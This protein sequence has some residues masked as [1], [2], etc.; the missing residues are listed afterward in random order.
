MGRR[1]EK[2]RLVFVLLPFD[3]PH[4]AQT[5][6]CPQSQSARLSVSLICRPAELQTSATCNPMRVLTCHHKGLAE[7]Y[8]TRS[9]SDCICCLQLTGRKLKCRPF[10]NVNGCAVGKSTWRQTF[11]PG[12]ARRSTGQTEPHERG[13]CK[14]HFRPEVFPTASPATGPSGGPVRPRGLQA[15]NH[16]GLVTT[17]QDYEMKELQSLQSPGGGLAT[18][19]TKTAAVPESTD[20]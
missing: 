7:R 20:Y 13:T 9:G 8:N 5:R 1:T 4:R 18:C 16:V 6:N 3:A 10:Y 11:P 17:C 12:F 14:I 19:K 2:K 15:P